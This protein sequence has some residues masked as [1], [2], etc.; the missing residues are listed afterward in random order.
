MEY[1]IDHFRF[2]KKFNEN[3]LNT[4]LEK[5]NRLRRFPIYREDYYSFFTGYAKKNYNLIDNPCLCKSQNDILLSQTDRHCVDF[6][7]V[8]CKSCGLI[9]AKQYFRDEDVKDMYKN[10]Y[11]TESYSKSF[12]EKYT[13]ETLFEHQKKTSKFKYDLLSKFKKKDFKNLKIMDVGG[14]IG[15]VLD[16]FGNDNEKY[17][18]DFYDPYLNY[19]KTKGIQ[20]RK[21]L[22]EVDFQ[23]DIVIAS[24]V[25]EHWNN[26]E[27]EIK[28]LI[29]IQKKNETMNYIEFPGV[30]SIKKGRRDGDILGDIHI[31]H[32]YYF[33]SYVFENL[34]NR[35]GFEKVYLDSFIKSIFVYT[36]KRGKLINFYKK[37]KNDLIAAEKTRKL[38]VFKNLIKKFVPF[39]IIKLIRKIRDKKID[40]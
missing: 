30:D 15:G 23:P 11:R 4:F 38:Q 31:P 35:H 40:Y 34:M 36:G 1:V 33:T 13:E 21:G 19:A 12:K 8:I 28:K 9:R 29:S 20:I 32:V 27:K 10:F 17:L 14:G 5:E 6:V 39:S 25:I 7:T 16:H 2:K 22:D 26:F 18:C 37:C 3:E 24:H